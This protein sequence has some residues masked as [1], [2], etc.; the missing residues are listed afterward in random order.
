MCRGLRTA[1]K[2]AYTGQGGI[3]GYY[4]G[5]MLVWVMESSV[6]N[7]RHPPRAPS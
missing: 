1:D 3:D 7:E 5:T 2:T 6:A 4:L